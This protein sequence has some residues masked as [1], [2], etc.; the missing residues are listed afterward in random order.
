[1]ATSSIFPKGWLS[2][3]AGQVQLE[4]I[5][6]DND[7]RRSA[8]R[9]QL[10]VAL[11][12]YTNAGKSSLMRALTGSEVLVADKL[13][14]TLD[15]TVRALQPETKPRVLVSDT[16]G[17][18]KKLPQE[19]AARSRRVVPIHAC[20]GARSVTAAVRRRCVRSDV[21]IAAR[22]EA[23]RGAAVCPNRALVTM[24]SCRRAASKA[25]AEASVERSAMTG[26]CLLPGR[27][28]AACLLIT[29][30]ADNAAHRVQLGPEPEG[31]PSSDART[32][33]SCRS[34]CF[35]TSAAAI[36]QRSIVPASGGP[37]IS[38]EFAGR[39]PPRAA[40][41]GIRSIRSSE[42]SCAR[43]GGNPAAR[44]DDF[45]G[46]QRCGRSPT[47]DDIRVSRPSPSSCPP[48]VCSSLAN[49]SSSRRRTSDN[50]A[51]CRLR[52]SLDAQIASGRSTPGS[53]TSPTE[54]DIC[55]F[56]GV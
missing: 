20:R 21:Q 44:G 28:D 18:I 50:F 34:I 4:D 8:R 47:S 25:S 30:N 1:M 7:Q 41:R 26:P 32:S 9:D 40:A 13:F 29:D 22:G 19:A 55:D 12:G 3:F 56:R 53:P 43:P 2:T 11:V 14:A 31:V 16:V 10:R 24:S 6:R 37:P 35:W 46:A 51:F 42:M 5:Q 36:F 33:P 54:R 49:T 48:P 39:H 15:T 45:I 52:G 27:M 23:S 38:D 17:F